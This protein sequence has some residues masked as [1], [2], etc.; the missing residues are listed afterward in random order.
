MDSFAIVKKW[1]CS[2]FSMFYSFIPQ[3]LGAIIEDF[4]F[5]NP[6]QLVL[7]F[8]SAAL[9]NVVTIHS[10]SRSR[11]MGNIWQPSWN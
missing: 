10:L 7:F 6:Y 9:P 2:I 3:L 1:V 8:I 4:F 5:L 11:V